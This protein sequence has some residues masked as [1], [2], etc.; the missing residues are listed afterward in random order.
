[1]GY[2]NVTREAGSGQEGLSRCTCQLGLLD[3]EE[4]PERGVG[5][6]EGEKEEGKWRGDKRKRG[7][8][9]P[10]VYSPPYMKSWMLKI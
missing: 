7:K 9:K 4:P 6:G 8:D 3:E 5:R 2:F 1:M 10:A